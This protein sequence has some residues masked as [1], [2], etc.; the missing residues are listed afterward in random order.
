M[1]YFLG[2]ILLGCIR[3]DL[4]L[5]SSYSPT[6]GMKQPDENLHI[7]IPLAIAA[8]D[9]ECANYCTQRGGIFRLVAR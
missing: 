6:V 5:S 7:V 4:I 9:T 8:S 1:K 2:L 3:G